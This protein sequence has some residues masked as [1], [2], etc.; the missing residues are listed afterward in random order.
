MF[1]GF[2]NLPFWSGFVRALTGKKTPGEPGYR[3]SSSVNHLLGNGVGSRV[4]KCTRSHVRCLG[5]VRFRLAFGRPKMSVWGHAGARNPSPPSPSPFRTC[6]HASLS[7]GV[8]QYRRSTFPLPVFARN[9]HR[10]RSA[11]R[12]RGFCSQ[13]SLPLERHGASAGG[14]A[15]SRRRHHHLLPSRSHHRRRRCS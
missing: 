10:G 11:A 5:P 13:A 1:C 2:R 4:P 6:L 3:Y 12:W 9:S 15:A 14:R 7:K 8:G